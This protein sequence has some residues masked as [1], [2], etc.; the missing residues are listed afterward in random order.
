VAHVTTQLPSVWNVADAI[1]AKVGVDVSTIH[2]TGARLSN[3]PLKY[4]EGFGI[5]QLSAIDH[6]SR[7]PL[8]DAT[9]TRTSVVKAV[10]GI[11]P[12]GFQDVP[13]FVE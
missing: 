8:G 10:F 7:V 5:Y 4:V 11:V 2:A 1:P 6:V 13:L 3:L 9:F 12:N